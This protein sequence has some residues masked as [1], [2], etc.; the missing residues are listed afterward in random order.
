MSGPRVLLLMLIGVA[1]ASV[2]PAPASDTTRAAL[3]AILTVVPFGAK[4]G[5]WLG[6]YHLGFWPGEVGRKA[7]SPL[8]QGFIEVTRE[9]AATPVSKR[10]R[11]G[12]FL[13]HDQ[14]DVW[15]KYV[16]LQPRLLDKLER[17]AEALEAAG[18]PS[19][20]HVMS[21]FRT[22]QYNAK[23][24]GP[25]GGRASDSQHMYGGAADV[26]VDADGNGMM[27]DLDRDG[28]VT[29][30]D[31]RLL[32]RVAEGVEKADPGLVGGLG[33][34][35]ATTAHGPFVHV[36]ARGYRARW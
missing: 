16:V 6:R 10:F 5:G 11:L 34:Y 13:T 23:G 22:P 14:R 25:K 36:D 30:A 4:I 20:L 29:L 27:D 31:A 33:L 7:G 28:R 1:P 15:P 3:P 18:L 19:R 26:F 12:D 35:P 8:P 21:G 32:Q 17:L 24:V 9:N 2:A